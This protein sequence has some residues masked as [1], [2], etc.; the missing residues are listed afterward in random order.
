MKR[1]FLLLLAT[2]IGFSSIAAI[3][4]TKPV[5]GITS[6]S[7]ATSYALGAFTATN[8]ALLVAFV[9][10]SASVLTAPTMTGGGFT[11]NLKSYAIVGSNAKYIFW[12][13]ATSA[14]STTAT[15]DCTGDQASAC[16]ISLISVTGHDNTTADP[17]KQVL[18]PTGTATS[19]DPGITFGT[20]LDTN[21]GYFIGYR[22]GFSTSNTATAPG[23][24]TEALDVGTTSPSV[25]AVTAWRAGGETTTG[26][27]TFTSASTTW[28][29][30]GCEIYVSG[31]GPASQTGGG[32]FNL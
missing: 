18:I 8:G 29:E 28:D 24:W 12:A 32:F 20:A 10:T 6:T 27:F 1:T 19:A 5:N 25:N 16:S 31:A 13:K 21:N 9:F 7:N 2:I 11:W 3:A 14:A 23:S 17:I 26:P 15:F 4:I 22:G 30:I